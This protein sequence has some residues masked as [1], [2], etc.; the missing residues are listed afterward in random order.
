MALWPHQQNVPIKKQAWERRRRAS[1][2]GPWWEEELEGWRVPVKKQATCATVRR[3]PY[4]YK[5]GSCC[6]LERSELWDDWKRVET[7][8]AKRTTTGNAIGELDRLYGNFEEEEDADAANT[9]NRQRLLRQLWMCLHHLGTVSF[10]LFHALYRWANN[11]FYDTSLIAGPQRACLPAA[12][13]P[14]RFLSDLW[15]FCILGVF[16]SYDPGWLERRGKL[17]GKGAYSNFGNAL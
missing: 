9:G 5:A 11:Q 4:R 10:G 3:R 14:V 8:L 13:Q 17:A 6:D 12:S 7:V 1:R 15:A 2:C 16:L